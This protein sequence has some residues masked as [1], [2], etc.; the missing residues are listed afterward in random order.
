MEDTVHKSV[1]KDTVHTSVVKDTVHKSVVEDTV[2]KSA[3]VGQSNAATGRLPA[4]TE[5]AV[6]QEMKILNTAASPKWPIRSAASP[7]SDSDDESSND[8]SES[9]PS[10]S[11]SANGNGNDDG[12]LI[13]DVD[14]V[15]VT[16]STA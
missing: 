15:N 6:I 16:F 4:L 10:R 1:V 9:T 13:L 3:I 7:D 12:H 8:S 5:L 11:P 2:H 14:R